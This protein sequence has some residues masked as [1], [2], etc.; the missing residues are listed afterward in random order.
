MAVDNQAGYFQ[1]GQVVP[2]EVV[3]S[4]KAGIDLP[5]TTAEYKTVGVTLRVTPRI[6]ADGRSIQLRTEAESTQLGAP[7]DLGG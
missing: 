1:V 3:E 7:V 2:S 4:P 5:S 6:S